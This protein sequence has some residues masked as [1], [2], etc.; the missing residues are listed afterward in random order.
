MFFGRRLGW[1]AV[2]PRS[3][4][5]FQLLLLVR[6]VALPQAQT[7]LQ[8]AINVDALQQAAGVPPS[9]PAPPAPVCDYSQ[10]DIAEECPS[11]Y[12]F[13][14]TTFH[15]ELYRARSLV[16]T[17][18]IGASQAAVYQLLKLVTEKFW[19]A[20]ECPL[21]VAATYFT[22]AQSF[23]FQGKLRR[24]LALVHMGFI[25]VRD[26]GFNECTPW[27]VQGWDMLLAGRNLAAVVR[28][29]DD[30]SV[31]KS[32]LP[33]FRLPSK[34]RIAIVSICAYA[35]DEPVRVIG[36]EN[37]EIY[38]QLHGYDLVAITD[39]GQIAPNVAAGMDVNDGVHKPFFWKVNAVKNVLESANPRY[40]W[41]L[42]IDCD[43]F[44]MEPSRTIDSVIEMYTGNSTAASRLGPLAFGESQATSQLRHRLHPMSSSE[45]SLILATDSTGINNGIWLLRNTPWAHDFLTRWW[46]SDI[47]QGPGKNHNCSDQSTMQHQLLY[48]NSMTIDSEWDSVEGPLWVPEVRVAAQEHLQSF[49]AATAYTVLSRE[50]QDGDFIKHHPGCHYYKQPCQQLYLEAHSIFIQKVQALTGQQR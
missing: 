47:L 32:T 42:W 13:D 40:E 12:G 16:F 20:F 49:H 2:R 6:L 50:W 35:P 1:S 44:F 25:F 34:P 21:A 9:A 41:V 27:P 17:G 15:E 4:W 33:Q 30:Q 48:D 45:V 8:A 18:D 5:A 28:A 7:P 23:A 10:I 24:A 11:S 38:A 29:L 14:W 43:G 3:P 22:L 37:H 39:A 36:M 31:L 26:K 19:F 46:H